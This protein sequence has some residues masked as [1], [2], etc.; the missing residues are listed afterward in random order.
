MEKIQCSGALLSKHA[1]VE[2]ESFSVTVQMTFVEGNGLGGAVVGG[3]GLGG[4]HVGG[5]A[6]TTSKTVPA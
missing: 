4:A 5:G 6:K 1:C 3:A 2:L